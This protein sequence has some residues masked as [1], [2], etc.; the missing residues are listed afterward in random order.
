M[1]FN[2]DRE[3]WERAGT[4]ERYII[5]DDTYLLEV[6][7]AKAQES[8]KGLPQLNLKLNLAERINDPDWPYNRWTYLTITLIPKGERGHGIALHQLK[9]LGLVPDENG[10]INIVPEEL[11]GRRF[12]AFVYSEKD[13]KGVLRQ[14]LNH[15]EALPEPTAEPFDGG[16]PSEEVPF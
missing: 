4:P 11:A 9:V 7:E 3:E 8:K 12:N 16:V 14:R 15:L 13:D 5:P 10:T 6:A 2:V 1:Q